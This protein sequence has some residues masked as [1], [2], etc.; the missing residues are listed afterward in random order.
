MTHHLRTILIK[1]S[2]RD[3]SSKYRT[4]KK[5]KYHRIEMLNKYNNVKCDIGQYHIRPSIRENT[6]SFWTWSP[7]GVPNPAH[8]QPY[9]VGRQ[10]TEPDWSSSYGSTHAVCNL[11]LCHRLSRLRPIQPVQPLGTMQINRCLGT[12]Y[13]QKTRS[14]SPVPSHGRTRKHQAHNWE[15]RVS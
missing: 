13:F 8:D 1:W 14:I 12:W 9:V 15:L 7:Y 4:N 3:K 10:T 6:Q 11:N 5:G 2:E